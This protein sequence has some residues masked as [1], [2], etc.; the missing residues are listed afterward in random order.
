[1]TT[2]LL[3]DVVSW[4]LVLD[5]SGNIAVCNAPYAIAQDVACAIRLFQGELWYDTSQGVPYFQNILGHAPPL[6]VLKAAINTA[7]LSV[8][9]VVA[10]QTYLSSGPSRG[11][12]GQCQVTDEVGRLLVVTGN[13]GPS[14]PTL[15]YVVG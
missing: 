10:S 12:I 8:P 2:S 1:M 6:G 9:A 13:L 4:D 11:I 3:L 15:V 7:A 14:G 5:A